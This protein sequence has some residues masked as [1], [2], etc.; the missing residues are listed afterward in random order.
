MRQTFVNLAV[1]ALILASA[2]AAEAQVSVHLGPSTPRLELGAHINFLDIWT[3]ATGTLGGRFGKRHADWMVSEL[4]YD[5]TDWEHGGRTTRL[6]I[7]GVRLQSPVAGG[8]RRPFAT[9]GVARAGGMSFDWS[10]VI[11]MGTRMES[12][13]GVLAMRL[14]LQWFTRGRSYPGPF[15][16]ARLLVGLAVGIP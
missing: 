15:E 12:P 1:A 13:G 2:R 9:I 11:A 6:L 5:R 14:D 7:A 8:G 3:D 16:R 4:S 10:P